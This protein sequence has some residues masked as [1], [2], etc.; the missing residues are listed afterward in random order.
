MYKI[1]ATDG[2]SGLIDN[3]VYVRKHSN[4]SFVLSIA[5]EAEGIAVNNTVYSILD[6]SLDGYTHLDVF[7]EVP[8]SSIMDEFLKLT[9]VLWRNAL[10]SNEIDDITISEHLDLLPNWVAQISYNAGD[11]VKF[12]SAA[13]RC[14]QSHTSQ[15]NWTPD[16]TSS[17][18]SMIAG[19]TAEFPQWSQ[20]LGSFD[21]YSKGD[22][23]T[24]QDQHYISEEYNNVWTPGTYGW[25]LVTDEDT[26][27]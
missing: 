27:E 8:A 22:K 11:V 1:H 9:G 5:A 16:S 24:Y 3:P 21:T 25:K 6:K 17:L 10:R 12:Q 26:H 14:I 15:D 4:G 23:V 2:F 13:Y 18:W 20:P 7:D 19:P